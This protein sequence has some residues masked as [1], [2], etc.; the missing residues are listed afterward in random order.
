MIRMPEP[1]KFYDKYSLFIFHLYDFLLFQRRPLRWGLFFCVYFYQ[2]SIYLCEHLL[3]SR[4]FCTITCFNTN[5]FLHVSRKEKKNETPQRKMK[6]V[7]KNSHRAIEIKK[8]HRKWRFV[9]DK[10]AQHSVSYMNVFTN[11]YNTRFI[12]R[13]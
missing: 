9:C 10:D 13:R 6:P 5:H 8:R 12:H 3:E 11:F 1:F 7:F 4:F 2:P